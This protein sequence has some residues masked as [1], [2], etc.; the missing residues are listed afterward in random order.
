MKLSC[1]TLA[2]NLAATVAGKFIYR[3]LSTGVHELGHALTISALYKDAKP[4]IKF[5]NYGYKGGETAWGNANPDP[6]YLGHLVGPCRETLI[7]AA[8]PVV[9]I[10]MYL[11]LRHFFPNSNLIAGLNIFGSINLAS[12][13]LSAFKDLQ[14]LNPEKIDPSTGSDFLQTRISG[15]LIPAAGLITAC[16][17]NGIFSIY[18][19]YNVVNSQLQG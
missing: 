7:S 16:V 14:I 10:T 17:A 1:I 13:A 9:E 8:G 15:G 3:P 12:Y 11:A 19:L 5:H 18:S 6:T 4:T 2:T